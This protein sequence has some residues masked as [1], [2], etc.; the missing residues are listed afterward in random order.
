MG[1]KLMSLRVVTAP[2]A[3]AVLL[4]DVE[5]HVRADLS[6]E[7]NLVEIYIKAVT[8]K[9]ESYLKR[10]ICTQTLELAIDEF[11]ASKMKL[12][13]GQV[14]SI[15]SITYLDAD[16]NEQTVDPEIYRITSSDYLLLAYD[17]SWPS[18]RSEQESITITYVAGYGA[19]ADIPAEIKAWIL[20]NVATLYENRET[21]TIGAGGVIDINTVAN[22]L[23][24]PLVNW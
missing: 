8:S 23:I 1:G 4:S 3:Q 5:D 2:T 15:T 9:A 11:P 6:A 21:V 18:Y 12:P 22:G 19:T 24:D 14:Q 20:L 7:S 13:A 17:K 16:G 10:S